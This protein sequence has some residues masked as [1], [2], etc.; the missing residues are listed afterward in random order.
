VPA[1]RLSAVSTALGIRVLNRT[2]LARQFL[3]VRQPREPLAVVEHLVG[4]QAQEPQ[5]PYQA[6]WARIDGFEPE[7]LS[8]LLEERSVVRSWLLRT[9]IHLASSAVCLDLALLARAVNERNYRASP[10]ARQAAGIELEALLRLAEKLLAERPL[11]RS[12]LGVELARRWPKVDPAA[13]AY[14]ATYLLP[15]VQVPPR[16]LWRRSGVAR[17]TIIERWLGAAPSATPSVE[18]LF[19]RYLRAYGP[20]S[21]ADFRAWSGLSGIDAD[22]SSVA[23]LRTFDD[24]R[25]RRLYDV[26]DAPLI[27]GEVEAPVRF[28]PPFDNVILGHADRSRIVDPADR[29][30]VGAD[31]LM[32]VFLVDGFVAGSWTVADGTLTV[33]PFGRLTRAAL[34]AVRI[35]G[36]RLLEFIVP[37]GK[38]RSFVLG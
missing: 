7:D 30:R 34:R 22:L 38:K 10:F 33:Q 3:L 2:L 8:R 12:E 32:R 11:T 28:L 37:E 14:T 27:E 1:P 4:V 29:G 25:G 15:L 26:A 6:L 18:R 36:E 5:A 21:V 13:L 19:L 9:T 16:G 17:M 35:E 24:P 31:R 23:G 20:A